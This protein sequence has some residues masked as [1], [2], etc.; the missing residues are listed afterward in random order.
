[1]KFLPS[2]AVLSLALDFGSA[3]TDRY[4][5]ANLDKHWDAG[6]SFEHNLKKP[7]NPGPPDQGTD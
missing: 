1:M 4:L 2:I 5:R 7:D 6:S 3:K